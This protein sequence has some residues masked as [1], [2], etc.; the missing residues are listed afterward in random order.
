[1]LTAGQPRAWR[2]LL[3]GSCRASGPG[4]ASP[5]KGPAA[6]TTLKKMLTISEEPEE[7]G[8]VFSSL[9]PAT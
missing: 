2:A 5:G 6:A 3:V 8:C 4:K 7:V 9:I 1:M